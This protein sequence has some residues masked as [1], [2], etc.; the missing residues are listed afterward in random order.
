MKKQHNVVMLYTEKAIDGGLFKWIGPSAK[1]QYGEIGI[2]N[3]AGASTWNRQPVNSRITIPQHLYIVSEDDAVEGD[4]V[5]NGTQIAQVNCL[6]VNDPNKHL[7]R[8]I[9]ATTDF[10]LNTKK[11]G[12]GRHYFIHAIPTSFIEAYKKAYNEGSPITEV[13]LEYDCD[14]TQMPNKVID[15]IKTRAD[16]TVII[17]QAKNYTKDELKQQMNNMLNDLLCQNY[18]KDELKNLLKNPDSNKIGS[19]VNDWLAKND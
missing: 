1:E 17:N 6:T 10:A 15:I 2:Y 16:N 7:H 13:S 18:G 4:W 9:V 3:Y 5:T 12:V 14:H 11:T 8:K 19:F